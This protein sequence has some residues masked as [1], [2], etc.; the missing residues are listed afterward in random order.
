MQSESPKADFTDN[1]YCFACS[2][3]NPIGLHL[4]FSESSDGRYETV[5]TPKREHQ[6]Y[7]GITHGGI[8]ATV[9]DEVM[10]R[11]VWS[12]GLTAP[13]ARLEIELKAPALTGDAV[14]IT[15]WL[16]SRSGRVLRL[17]SEARRLSDNSLVAIGRAVCL[18]LKENARNLPQDF[19]SN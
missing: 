6:G 1:N 2:P 16:E 10:A 3:E 13:T 14:R 5:F 9:L 18:V 11:Y 12:R 4:T 8:V 17:C 15:G 7:A 19:G